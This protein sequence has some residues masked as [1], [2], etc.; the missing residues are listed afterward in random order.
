MVESLKV[1]ISKPQ[2][3]GYVLDQIYVERLD[4]ASDDSIYSFYENTNGITIDVSGEDAIDECSH[5]Y[6]IVY[7][8]KGAG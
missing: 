1:N 8:F 3:E 5:T 4:L 2:V 6:T 7:V